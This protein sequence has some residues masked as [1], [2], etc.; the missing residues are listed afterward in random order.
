M[1]APHPGD[2]DINVM[3]ANRPIKD[4]PIQIRV[5]SGKELDKLKNQIDNLRK[6]LG[7]PKREYTEEEEN[8]PKFAENLAQELDDLKEVENLVKEIQGLRKKLGMEP[9]VF[10]EEELVGP[11]AIPERTAERDELKDRLG[12][13]KKVDPLV[14]KIQKL[15]KKMDMS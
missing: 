1:G 10:D 14:D 12:Q 4:M 15:R 5:Q 6:K 8:D 3:I 2:L 11:N 7:L 13:K 9:R